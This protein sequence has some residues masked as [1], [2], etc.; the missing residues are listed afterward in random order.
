VDATGLASALGQYIYWHSADLQILAH[1]NHFHGSDHTLV[2]G[3]ADAAMLNALRAERHFAG[4]HN[5]LDPLQWARKAISQ[6]KKA[7][8]SLKCHP[9]GDPAIKKIGHAIGT[10]KNILN[11]IEYGTALGS[12]NGPQ[13]DAAMGKILSA[14]GSYLPPGFRQLVEF[15]GKAWS[16]SANAV[17]RLDAAEGPKALADL[18]GTGGVD[19]SLPTVDNPSIPFSPSWAHSVLGQY[20]ATVPGFTAAYSPNHPSLGAIIRSNGR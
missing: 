11:A 18:T 15:Y 14:L 4:E 17:D 9:P 8:H 7:E 2:L 1:L 5:G 6:L 3:I 13:Q 12:E 10:L 19:V 20:G 16:A